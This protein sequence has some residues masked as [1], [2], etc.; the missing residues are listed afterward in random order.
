MKITGNKNELTNALQ[1]VARAVASKPQTPILSGIYLRAEG[2]TLEL[3]ATNY[4]IGLVAH[5]EAEI[6]EAGELTVGGRYF[7]EVVRK[8]P[9]ENV[10]LA[11]AADEK[12]VHIES[13]MAKFTLLSMNAAEFPTIQPLKGNLDFAIK[14]NILRDL[15]KKTVFACSNDEA[16]P[17]FTGCSL[18]VTENKV[19][20]TD[21]A[22]GT[23]TN[24]AG[25]KSSEFGVVVIEANGATLA[26]YRCPYTQGNDQ[27]VGALINDANKG[28]YWTS[29][30]DYGNII[31]SPGSN[32]YWNRAVHMRV[33]NGD[34][35]V[36]NMGWIYDGHPIRAILNE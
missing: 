16:R 12:I 7:Q 17:V 35:Y 19:T 29:T 9:G 20:I 36:N 23:Y 34:N 24:S 21:Y 33:D 15:I 11:C 13:A 28:R 1:I 10:K 25:Y 32:N 18:E 22:P 6:E 27:G 26:L 3:Q 4:E 14:D 5:I 2:T 30:T 31:Y 8:L